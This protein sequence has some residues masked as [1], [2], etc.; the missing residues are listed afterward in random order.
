MVFIII[1]AIIVFILAA[2]QIITHLVI[3]DLF[4]RAEYSK[5]HIGYDYDYFK[6]DYPRINVSFKSGENTLQGYIYGSEND[7]GLIVLAHGIGSG[8]EY[9]LSEIT[10]FVDKGWRVF[11]YDGTG[12]CTSEGNSIKGLPQSALDMDS[13][14]T[15]IENDAELSALPKFTMGHSWGGYAAAAVLN[16]DHEIKAAATIAGYDRPMEM[17]NE[18]AESMMEKAA[19]LIYPFMWIDSRFSFGNNLDISAVSGINKSNAPVLVIHGK[20][21]ETVGFDRSSIISKSGKI[22]NPNV[23]YYPIEGEYSTHIG[24]FF[25]EE[26]NEYTKRLKDEKAEKAAEKYGSGEIPDEFSDEFFSTI[27]IKKATEPNIAM[28][29]KINEFFADKLENN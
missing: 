23:E 17:M 28:Y 7:K 21:D 6:K 3:S 19:A 24:V 14:L 15:F 11:A 16:F 1:I 29:E 5:Y 20:N 27:D 8:H 12:C 9:R 25:T 10:W 26:A 18:F 22:T 13:A 2:V 4:Q